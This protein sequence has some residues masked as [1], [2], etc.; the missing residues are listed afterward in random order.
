MNLLKTRYSKRI[1][2]IK[3]HHVIR[4]IV[5]ADDKKEAMEKAVSALNQLV[6]W[7][8]DSIDYGTFFDD[9]KSTMSGKARWGNVPVCVKASSKE[10]K[11]LIKDGMDATERDFKETIKELREMLKK[12]ND[13]ELFQ[14]E[15]L[16]KNK[17]MLQELEE[18]DNSFEHP[19]WF[20]YQCYKLG[21]EGVWLYNEESSSISSP[22]E[23]KDVLDKDKKYYEGEGKENPN[24]DKEV[25]VVPCDVHT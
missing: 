1:C 19:N 22:K 7:G 13:D 10:G 6:E 21:K 18:K 23:L 4:F 12:Y 17:Q 11:R 16:D 24:K 8:T 14:K 3:M 20:H 15:I 25:W 2:V 5:Y 9:D